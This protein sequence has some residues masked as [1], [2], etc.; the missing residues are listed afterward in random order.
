MQ[1]HHKNPISYCF[2]NILASA[3][4]IKVGELLSKIYAFGHNRNGTARWHLNYQWSKVIH[5]HAVVYRIKEF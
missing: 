1:L 3:S 2:S 5:L 4:L